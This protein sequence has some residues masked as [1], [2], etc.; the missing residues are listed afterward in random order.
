MA[1]GLF[2]KQVPEPAAPAVAPQVPTAAAAP[3]VSTETDSA[4]DS[5]KEILEL[6]ELE[7]GAMIRQLERAAS[8]VADGAEATAA[9]LA[10]IRARTDALT[11]RSSDAQGTATT[12]SQAADRFTHSAEGIGAQ[13]RSASQLA[14]DAAAAAREAT[15]NVDRLRESSAA[16]GN[17]VNLIAQIARQTTLLAL[18]STIE[19]ARAGAA[20]KG[21]AVVATEVKALAV[22]TQSATEEITRKIEALQKDATGSADAVHRI[23]QAIEKIRPVFENVNGAVAE[24]NEI[25]GEMGQNAASASHFIVSVGTSAGEIDSA[26]REAAAHGDNVAKAGKAVT[27]FAQKLKARCAVLLRQDEGGDPRKNERL[28]CSLKIEITTARG[29]VTAP[30]YEI[31]MDGILIGGPDAEKLPAQETLNATLQE[32]GACRIRIGERSKAGSQARFEAAT[33]EL[34]EKIEDRMWAIHEENAELVTRAIEAGSAL[35][36]IFENGLASGAIAIAD[37]FDTDYVE[38]AGTNPVQYR[39]KML[40]WA[41]RTLPAFQEAFLA[42]DK[43]M[44]FCVMIDQ[45]GYLPVHNKLYSQP[46]RP[47]DV[48]YNTANSRNRRIFDDAAGLAAGRNQRAYLIQTYARDMGGGNTVMMRE[49]DVPVRVRGRHWGGFRTA[50]K[51]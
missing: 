13:V 38:I 4:K 15:A 17:V 43:R 27:A 6:L 40:D 21:F 26:T 36:K 24:Q 1:F 34:R 47:G 23:S 8:S 46:Q 12:F 32:I 25:T 49:I 2:R 44:A 33:A 7:L 30:V 3:D 28:P 50:Y 14:D 37:M 10:T 39:T 51:L 19:A 29:I 18:N 11:G 9:K 42:R 31:A 35:S 48:A 41:E 20:G 45:N 5:S 16:I 22:Q